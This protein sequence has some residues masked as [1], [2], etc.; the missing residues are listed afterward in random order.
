MEETLTMSKARATLPQIPRKLAKERHPRALTITQH[1]K[2]VLAV[3]P[4][5]FYD[6]LMETLEIMAD[7]KMM[8]ALKQSAEDIKKG[9]TYTSDEVRKKLGL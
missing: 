1:G 2:P 5:E 4:Y 6:S 8:E 3:L 9:R 7:P